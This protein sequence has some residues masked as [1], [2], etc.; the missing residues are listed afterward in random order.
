MTAI[1]RVRNGNRINWKVGQLIA[2]VHGPGR[3]NIFRFR[4]TSLKDGKPNTHRLV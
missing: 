3:K 1:Q 4:I 2:F